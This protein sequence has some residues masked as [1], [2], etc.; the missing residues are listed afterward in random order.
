MGSSMLRKDAL[1]LS[2]VLDEPMRDFVPNL[3]YAGS[4]YEVKNAMVVGKVLVRDNAAQMASRTF[5]F[6]GTR[7]WTPRVPS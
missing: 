7:D 4:G 6:S 1:N 2:P 5:K 3:V